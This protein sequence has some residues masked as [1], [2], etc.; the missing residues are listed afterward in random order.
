MTSPVPAPEHT[1]TVRLLLR[2]LDARTKRQLAAAAV[3]SGLLA[4]LETAAVL[5]V[6]PLVGL[7]TG[8]PLDE[9]GLGELWRA[10]GEPSR[11]VFG[12]LLV[13]AVVGMFVLKDV[14]ALAFAWWQSGILARERVRLSTRIFRT[15]MQSPYADFRRRST[16]EVMG[17]MN[18][19]VSTSLGS[20]AGGLMSA[21]SGSFTIVALVTALL[22][23]TP[24][25]AVIALV[26]FALAAVLYMR[27]V[28]PRVG[29][30]GQTMFRG[31][32]ELTIAGLQGLNGFKEVKIRHSSEYFVRR[33]RDGVQ[34]VE[35]AS[36]E[37]NFFGA[38]TRYLLEILFILGVGVLLAV[39]F[40]ADPGGNIAGSLALFVA[41]G[42]RLLPNISAMVGAVNGIRMGRDSLVAVAREVE[43]ATGAQELPPVEE[44]APLTRSLV[45][46]NVHYA[47]PG[48][49]SEVIR[50]IDLEIPVGR[51]IALVG[52]S[53]AGKTT[54]VDLVLG[55]LAPTQGRITADGRDIADDVRA[56]QRNCA[57]VAQDVFLTE[58][59]VLQNIVFD[60][61][62]SEA[63]PVRLARAIDEAQLRDLEAMLPEGLDSS[64]GDWGTRLSGGQR[65]RV[66]IARALYRDPR[67]LVL[68]EATSALDN[69]TE[70]RITET[71]EALHG[72]VTVIVVAD[73]LSTVK[74]VDEIVFLADGRVRSRGSFDELRR[75]DPEFAH[76]VRLGD[77][78]GSTP[79]TCGG[80]GATAS[81]DGA[82]RSVGGALRAG[83]EREGSGHGR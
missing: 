47:Y 63:D 57:M 61:P 64:A 27:L 73:R 76:L 11:T 6:L 50:G 37:G 33:F 22:V 40:I 67:L 39:S 80:D 25:Q 24:L 18:A 34:D 72:R 78:S 46:E 68:D 45:L 81:T 31:S 28:R 48:A 49:E 55:L 20:V 69:V 9:G 56:W 79:A 41:A 54:L 15:V 52:G 8:A 44:A 21:L 1:G 59:S 60:A 42:F 32:V 58:E 83:E 4:L 12:L 19:A 16:G 35:R 14:A 5:A 10:V 65:Q 75:A 2:V 77:L 26:Y 13:V 17:V 53:G 30:A 82:E 51:S 74:N 3:I 36:R 38:A 66:G 70:R 29:R 7:A 71:I 62:V 43:D 23:A